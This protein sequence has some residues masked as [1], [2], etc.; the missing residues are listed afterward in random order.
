MY[1]HQGH[2]LTISLTLGASSQTLEEKT[3]MERKRDKQINIRL[4]ESEYLNVCLQVEKSGL[5]LS[6]Y[7]RKCILGK[8]IKVVSGI[9]ELVWELNRIGNNLNQLTRKVN[10][11]KAVELGD[12][13]SQINCNLDTVFEKIVKII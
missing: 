12:N 11:G 4:T 3:G 13:L 6:E 2:T 10:E 8:E 7:I 9:K 1:S 5:G